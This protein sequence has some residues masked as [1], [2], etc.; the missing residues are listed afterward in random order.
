MLFLYYLQKENYLSVSD[1][2][3][4]RRGGGETNFKVN[5]YAVVESSRLPFHLESLVNLEKNWKKK[6]SPD[7]QGNAGYF[8]I[9]KLENT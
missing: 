6:K 8:E 7:N 5:V 3:G 2:S 1:F 4:G 9:K